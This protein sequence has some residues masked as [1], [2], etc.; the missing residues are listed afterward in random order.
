MEPN[1][2]QYSPMAPGFYNANPNI[3]TKASFRKRQSQKRKQ[4]RRKKK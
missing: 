2:S 4:T 1:Y 3:K